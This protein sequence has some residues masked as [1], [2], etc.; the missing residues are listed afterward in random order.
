M[1]DSG[2]LF[3]AEFAPRPANVACGSKGIYSYWPRGA[4]VRSSAVARKLRVGH[5]QADDDDLGWTRSEFTF[6]RTIAQVVMAFTGFFIGAHV[7]K[8][9]GRRLMLIGIVVLSGSLFSLSFTQE[10]W[11][12]VA[13]NGLI[14]TVGAAMIGNLVVNVTISKWFVEKRGIAVALASMGVSMAVVLLTPA[15]TR[16]SMSGAGARAGAGWASGRSSLSCRLR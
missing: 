13:I 16:G 4:C 15:M 12:W 14:M 3:I 2:K 1:F 7:D 8:H 5:L 6:A 10:L 9:G 11:Q